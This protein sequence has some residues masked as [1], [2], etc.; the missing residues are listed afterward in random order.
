VVRPLM[1]SLRNDGILVPC[2]AA[3]LKWETVTA[4]LDSRFMS[5]STGPD[6][7]AQLE[8]K[9]AALTADEAHRLLKLWTVRSNSSH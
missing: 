4:V 5:G 6:E 8:R 9:F 2:K 1:Q 7:L 3:G